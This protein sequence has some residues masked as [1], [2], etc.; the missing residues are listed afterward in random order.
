V[1]AAGILRPCGPADPVI[2][3]RTSIVVFLL[4]FF[5]RMLFVVAVVH[6]CSL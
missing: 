3:M 5:L 2:E 4:L 1:Q 6:K